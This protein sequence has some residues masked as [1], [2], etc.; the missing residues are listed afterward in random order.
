M[1]LAVVHCG[2]GDGGVASGAD[3]GATPIDATVPGDAMAMS[4]GAPADGAAEGLPGAYRDGPDDLDAGA[5]REAGIVTFTLGVTA[6]SVVSTYDQRVALGFE[7]GY[8]DGV[9][10]ALKNPADYF[11]FASAHTQ[12]DAGLCPGSPDTQGAFR[13]GTAL[14]T[15]STSYGCKA[16]IEDSEGG[17]PDGGALGP[18]DR[19]YVGGG[20]VLRVPNPDGGT[21]AVLMVYHAEFHW[22]PQCGAENAPCFYGTLGLAVSM[23]DGV[24]FQ[25][26]GEII[27]SNISR[28]DWIADDPNSSLAIGAGPFALGD[29]DH[30][31]IDPATADPA[32]AFLYV[33]YVDQAYADAGVTCAS[34]Q[35]LGVA[36][37]SL[38]SVIDAA[39]ALDRAAAPT[40]FKKYYA[41]AF[42]Q[43]A[44]SG[45]PNDA[46]GAGLYSPLADATYEVSVLY[47][48][49]I[50]QVIMAAKVPATSQIGFRTSADLVMWP[51]VPI[52]TAIVSPTGDGGL[53][54]P[55]LIGETDD[56]TVGGAAPWLFY[57][58]G[59]TWK[60][61]TFERR[62]LQITLTP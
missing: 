44:A 12:A 39:F 34:K 51:T 60:T 40:L 30:H 11:L 14:D 21:P 41:G 42:D 22:G 24:T 7:F 23:D 32:S 46:V 6:A 4:P 35:C 49:A 57:T 28:P 36:R 15:I 9:L 62:E 56:T 58:N 53:R 38:K 3:A 47:D 10:G 17:A 8:V 45:D 43:P 1:A 25:K 19:D 18:F 16:L 26:L 5:V 52:A 48:R 13:L 59:D 2:G 27:Q 50:G 37:A 31:A 33:Y 61:S 20:P 55:S 54:Y 29:V